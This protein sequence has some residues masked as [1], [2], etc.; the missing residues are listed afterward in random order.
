[1]NRETD[2]VGGESPT[3]CTE[4]GPAVVLGEEKIGELESRVNVTKGDPV[5][6]IKNDAKIKDTNPPENTK[7]DIFLN[8]EEPKEAVEESAK[9]KLTEKSNEE[10]DENTTADESNEKSAKEKLA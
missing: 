4:C 2:K 10:S 8:M 7:K 3:K 6:K 1:M 9:D 5:P